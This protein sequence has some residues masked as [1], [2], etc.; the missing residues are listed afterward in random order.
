M[1]FALGHP[2]WTLDGKSLLLVDRCVPDG[3]YGIVVFSLDT[4]RKHCLTAPPTPNS[5]DTYLKLSPD[6]KTVAFIRS[7]TNGVS[8]LYVSALEGGNPR[9][10]TTDGS[11][12]GDF[13]WAA[14]GKRIIFQ[15][16]RGGALSDRLWRVS[17][18]GGNIEPETAYTHLGALSPDGQRIAYQICT[19]SAP[20]SIWRAGLSGPGG[21][22]VAR[23]QAV[24]SAIYDSQPQLSPDGTKLAFVSF[25]S[26]NIEIW[27]SDPD[28]S[29]PFQLTSF[30]GENTGTPRW[31][32]DGKW[33]V[34][35]RRPG[36][37]SRIYLLD[38]EGRNLHAFTNG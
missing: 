1:E 38:V 10:L 4:G 3:P 7:T 9:R 15:S 22:E 20:I 16:N 30:G 34:F 23:R 35:D 25:R 13:M 31:S 5:T 24:V 29:N 21:R 32:P 11:W 14:D 36:A 17:V 6:R 37:Q 2:E 18:D 27:R 8:E 26:G 19:S 12:I 28:G 33:I